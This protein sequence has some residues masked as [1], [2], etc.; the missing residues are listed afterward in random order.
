MKKKVIWIIVAVVIVTGVILGLTVFRNGKKRR[1][2]VQDGS[3]SAA[4]TSR[5]WS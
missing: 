4:A 2:Q 5:P 1:G 3:R